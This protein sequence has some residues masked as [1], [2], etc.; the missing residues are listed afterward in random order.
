MTKLRRR[1]L[2][3]GAAGM[4]GGLAVWQFMRGGAGT[5]TPAM[6]L[7]D[8]AAAARIGARVIEAAVPAVDMAA[9][10][11]RMAAF[12]DIL[13]T[14]ADAAALHRA[15]ATKVADDFAAGAIVEIDGWLLAQTE[16][17]LAVLA[18]Q[19]HADG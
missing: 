3:V 11:R 13:S 17:D 1:S 10:E 15:M 2:L 8:P 19:S 12:G 9:M 5:M 6:A 16:A 7:V 4:A 18:A 14:S